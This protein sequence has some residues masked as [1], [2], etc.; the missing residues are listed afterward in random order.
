MHD[1]RKCML[2]SNRGSFTFLVRCR[3]GASHAGGRP[4]ARLPLSGLEVAANGFA[5]TPS[6]T[7]CSRRCP[8]LCDECAAAATPEARLACVSLRAGRQAGRQAR[9]E[10]M[11]A[12][13]SMYYFVRTALDRALGFS[14]LITLPS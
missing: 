4:A 7:A 2:P 14:F 10:H 13:G 5:L 12:A 1:P 9:T 11:L 3:R 6:R 8:V